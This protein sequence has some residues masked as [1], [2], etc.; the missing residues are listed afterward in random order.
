MSRASVANHPAPREIEQT[1]KMYK[2]AQ[3]VAFLMIVF[4]V[5]GIVSSDSSSEP[6]S[7]WPI[8][9]VLGLITW[10]AARFGAWWNNG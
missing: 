9:G 7:F 1:S 10:I 3:L 6:S 5:I 2:G 8:V 4:S